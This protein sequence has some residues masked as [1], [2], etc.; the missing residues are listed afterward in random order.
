MTALLRLRV[1]GRVVVAVDCTGVL[2]AVEGPGHLR[3]PCHFLVAGLLRLHERGLLLE[4][5]WI[6][7]HGK[8][9]PTRW[10]PPSGFNEHRMRRLNER[11]DLAA[12]EAATLRARGSRRQ[13]CFNA[14]LAA[15]RWES[16]VLARA[17]A[18]AA[19]FDLQG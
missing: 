15:A 17:A 6:P 7:S 12:R 8:P 10:T 2:D 9:L 18:V 16:K 19:H 11:A 1:R 5:H 3:L 13:M 14:R 4:L